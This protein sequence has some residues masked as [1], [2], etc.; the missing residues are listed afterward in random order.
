MS[1][2]TINEIACS[3]NEIACS[4]NELMR[5]INEHSERGTLRTVLRIR[6]KCLLVHPTRCLCNPSLDSYP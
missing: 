4:I 3:I 2:C 6:S 5:T 1:V